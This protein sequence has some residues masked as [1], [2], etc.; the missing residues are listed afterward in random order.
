MSLSNHAR[1]VVIFGEVCCFKEEQIGHHDGCKDCS[2]IK[3]VQLS[4]LTDTMRLPNHYRLV[5]LTSQMDGR[6]EI[7]VTRVTWR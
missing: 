6:E 3:E 2:E 4:H 7:T 5:N 1:I